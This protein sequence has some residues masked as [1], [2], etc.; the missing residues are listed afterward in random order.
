MGAPLFL[1]Y[2]LWSFHSRIHP[3]WIAPAVLP[4]F[5]LMLLYWHGRRGAKPFLAIGLVLGGCVV[6]LMHQSNFIGKFTGQSLPGA[7]D[8]SRRVRAWKAT[9]D[10]VEAKR[11][12]LA[13]EGKP[14]FIIAA[15][16]GMT[17]LCTFYSPPARAALKSRPL[18]YVVDTAVPKNQFYFWPE[19]RYRDSRKGQNAIYVAE[20]DL[21]PLESGWF[22]KWLT[23][24]PVSY[25]NAPA[26]PHR[27]LTE[28]ILPEFESVTDLGEFDVKIG[29]R[30]F[31]R[32][33]LWACY[34]LK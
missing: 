4:L 16:Y 10:L 12:N 31:R 2:G 32:I 13:A 14:A 33:H 17:G 18:V 11:E 29:S 34:N 15:H 6:I 27:M 9:A 5:C 30:T 26:R 20:V 3:N 25:T 19:Y 23:H 21:P 7:L 28:Y 1:G 8:P 24:R 22:W